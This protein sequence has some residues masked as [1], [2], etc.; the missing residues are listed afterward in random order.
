MYYGEVI[1]LE[2]QR[3]RN[4]HKSYSVSSQGLIPLIVSLLCS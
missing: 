1:T 3:I 4:I 2:S